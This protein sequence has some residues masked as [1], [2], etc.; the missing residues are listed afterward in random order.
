MRIVIA[1]LIVGLFVLGWAGSVASRNGTL[2]DWTGQDTLLVWGL[3]PMAAGIL[4][5]RSLP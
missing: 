3:W 4:A 1:Y 2:D 5:E